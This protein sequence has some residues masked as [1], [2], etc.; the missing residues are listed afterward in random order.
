MVVPA[1]DKCL[2]QAKYFMLRMVGTAVCRCTQNS[3]YCYWR[4]VE[5]VFRYLVLGVSHALF[6][7][8][9]QVVLHDVTSHETLDLTP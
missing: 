4:L 1:Y 6:H 8:L 7:E 5:G 3:E 2:C 9:I